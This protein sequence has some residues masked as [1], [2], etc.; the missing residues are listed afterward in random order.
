[1][2]SDLIDASRQMARAI[3]EY[4]TDNESIWRKSAFVDTAHQMTIALKDLV[5]L[6]DASKTEYLD[7]LVKTIASHNGTIATLNYDNTIELAG[8]RLGVPVEVGLDNW[9]AKGS[10]A[11]PNTGI[12]LLKLHGSID[13]KISRKNIKIDDENDAALFRLNE[14]SRIKVDD[15]SAGHFGNEFKLPPSS[16]RGLI[17][18]AGNKLT[19]EGPFLELF[20]T[21][22]QRLENHDHLVTIGYSFG[23]QH[24]NHV[25]FRWMNQKPDRELTVVD[26]EGMTTHGHRLWQENPAIGKS[27]RVKL[28]PV[29]AKQGICDLF[30]EHN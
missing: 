22:E 21:F 7:P 17:F 5:W 26:R 18:G 6:E 29:G 16:N 10:F 15:D 14:V 24:I 11:K 25:I 28:L 8:D 27:S 23:D 13:W 2:N 19:E 30:S 3:E 20:R 4:V 9:S 1:L 12:E